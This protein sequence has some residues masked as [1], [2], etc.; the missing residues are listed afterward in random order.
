MVGYKASV[1]AG[2]G[3]KKNERRYIVGS[4]QRELVETRIG[5]FH[6]CDVARSVTGSV[7]VVKSAM[8]LAD[9]RFDNSVG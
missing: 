5:G 7:L 9:S 8:S 2:G 4:L 1:S 3:N 6:V